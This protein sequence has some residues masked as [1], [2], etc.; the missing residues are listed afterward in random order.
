[1]IRLNKEDPMTTQL[2]TSQALF[3]GLVLLCLIHI[4]VALGVA[5]VTQA[6]TNLR[7]VVIGTRKVGGHKQTLPI[8][9]AQVL[10]KSEVPSSQF[11]ETLATDSQGV[12]SVSNV[13]KGPVL[14]QV[15]AQGWPTA[16]TRTQLTKAN[17]TITIEMTA[18]E[19][20]SPSPTP[21]PSPSPSPSPTGV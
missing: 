10:V 9:G 12:A 11:E 16:G 2:P 3:I 5:A 4:D 18:P 13:R 1:M 21:A 15:T 20:A 14:I 7:V 19:A 17:E 6:T 8:A